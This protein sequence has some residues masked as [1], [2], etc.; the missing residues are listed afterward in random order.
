[1]QDYAAFC[2]Q[3]LLACFYR[4]RKY[5]LGS[6]DRIHAVGEA[7]MFLR[8]YRAEIDWRATEI[9][10]QVLEINAPPVEVTAEERRQWVAWWKPSYETARTLPDEEKAYLKSGGWWPPLC[11]SMIGVAPEIVLRTSRPGLYADESPTAHKL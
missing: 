10:A 1:M 2:Y 5:P 7:K 3:R 11:A 6:E 4:R 8:S 9:I